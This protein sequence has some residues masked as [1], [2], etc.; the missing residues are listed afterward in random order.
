M[1]RPAYSQAYE[2]AK[3][4]LLTQLQ[5]RELLD[6]RIRK[7][8]QTVKALGDL[9]GAPPEEID[10]LLLLEGF[11]IDARSGF[12][13]A[14]RRLFRIHQKALSPVE[15]RDDLLK[16][17]IGVGQMNLLA[18]I[19]TVLRRMVEAG[20]IEKTEDSRFCIAIKRT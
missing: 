2:T 8:R 1:A 3:L 17:A 19:H 14:I 7:L 13:D 9:C 6:Q 12:T 11:A 10:K 20:E 18:S 16:M 15:I 5:K 4:D